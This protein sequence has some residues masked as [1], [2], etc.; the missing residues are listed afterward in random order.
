MVSKDAVRSFSRDR[1]SAPKAE[2]RGRLA[3]RNEGR[4]AL[5]TELVLL[6]LQSKLTLV[7]PCDTSSCHQIQKA[8]FVQLR[9]PA[10][11][12]FKTSA[13]RQIVV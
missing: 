5:G 4:A 2:R 3:R 1:L 8:F 7:M 9:W 11:R 6:D 10:D 13:D 12:D